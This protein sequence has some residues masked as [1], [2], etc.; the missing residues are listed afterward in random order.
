MKLGPCFC[1]VHYCSIE[2]FITWKT[3]YSCGWW[4]EWE[5]GSWSVKSSHHT[6]LCTCL[7]VVYYSHYGRWLVLG[8]DMLILLTKQR[9]K[10][11]KTRSDGYGRTKY[12]RDWKVNL[13]KLEENKEATELM[14]RNQQ[15]I[16]EWLWQLWSNIRESCWWQCKEAEN[17]CWVA[18]C[19]EPC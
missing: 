2:V 3:R 12:W 15:R 13:E 16:Q 7:S 9:W 18:L 8:K 10:M 1:K 11:L 14:W 17:Q 4:R 6:W 5:P 19:W